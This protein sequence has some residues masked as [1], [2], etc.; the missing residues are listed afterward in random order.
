MLITHDFNFPLCPFDPIHL[1][2]LV[3][4]LPE[5]KFQSIKTDHLPQEA[6]LDGKILVQF[7]LH[8]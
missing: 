7:L 6:N 2:H 5:K 8:L 4:C 3:L 1:T